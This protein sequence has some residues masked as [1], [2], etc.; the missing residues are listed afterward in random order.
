MEEAKFILSIITLMGIGGFMF[1]FVR[2]FTKPKQKNEVLDFLNS[3]EDQREEN[4]KETEKQSGSEIAKKLSSGKWIIILAVTVFLLV[5]CSSSK[6]ILAV[7]SEPPAFPKMSVEFDPVKKI[8][9]MSERDGMEFEIF[10]EEL[11]IYREE[12]KKDVRE[13]KKAVE[14]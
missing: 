5:S 10:R 7:V 14:K 13:L 3:F 9:W 12:L 1:Y 8:F 6:I 4:R 11:K 2:I